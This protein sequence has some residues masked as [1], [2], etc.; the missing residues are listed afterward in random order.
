[1]VVLVISVSPRGGNSIPITNPNEHVLMV[2]QLV[3]TG[4][5]RKKVRQLEYAFSAS[6][7][8]AHR[9]QKPKIKGI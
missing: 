4:T 5:R 9:T 7:E 3:Y 8:K 2:I 6:N 1:M